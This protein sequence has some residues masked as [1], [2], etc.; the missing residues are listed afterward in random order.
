MNSI[1]AANFTRTV[2]ALVRANDDH[3]EDFALW[4]VELSTRA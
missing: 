4:V 1:E 3:A 2:A